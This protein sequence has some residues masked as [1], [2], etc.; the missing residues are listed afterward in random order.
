MK[1]EVREVKEREEVRCEE[2]VHMVYEPKGADRDMWHN[3]FS[4]GPPHQVGQHSE[5]PC[6]L[7]RP[8]GHRAPISLLPPPLHPLLHSA[9]SRHPYGRQH[10]VTPH[11]R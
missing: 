11:L 3:L 10:K 1:E 8:H 4:P 5:A 7:G 6:A 9:T 2:E